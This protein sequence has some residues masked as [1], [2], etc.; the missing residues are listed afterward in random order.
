MREK[1]GTRGLHKGELA[2]PGSASVGGRGGREIPGLGRTLLLPS[3]LGLIEVEEPQ[4]SEA[5]D[6]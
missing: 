2:A 1:G 5:H 3:R 4:P 6:K